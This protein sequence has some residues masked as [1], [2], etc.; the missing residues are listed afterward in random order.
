MVL[1]VG[2]SGSILDVDEDSR[3]DS[4]E[5]DPEELFGNDS[6]GDAVGKSLVTLV[7]VFA[8][9]PVGSLEA[10]VHHL[11]IEAHAFPDVHR[12]ISTHNTPIPYILSHTNRTTK[13]SPPSD[14]AK[15]LF[16]ETETG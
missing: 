15:V 14:T 3:S 8:L 16:Q 4:T 5:L 6:I 10:V 11:G 1:K 2:I 13:Q 9:F 12:Y 7:L